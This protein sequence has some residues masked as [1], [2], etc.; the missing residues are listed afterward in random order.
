MYTTGT[1]GR[2][3]D[4]M[5][6]TLTAS[7]TAFAASHAFETG[8]GFAGLSAVSDISWHGTLACCANTPM[9]A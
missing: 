6:G 5:S 1:H 7:G 8:L 9:M 2:S 4:A 3:V